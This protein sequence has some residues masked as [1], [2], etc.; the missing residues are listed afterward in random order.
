MNYEKLTAK[1]TFQ[2]GD[3]TLD[4]GYLTITTNFGDIDIRRKELRIKMNINRGYKIGSHI[5]RLS[6]SARKSPK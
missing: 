6:R 5:R 2:K 1:D 3:V 4:E